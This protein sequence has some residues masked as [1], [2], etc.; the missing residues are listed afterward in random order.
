MAYFNEPGRRLLTL[1]KLFIRQICSVAR[2]TSYSR[3]HI[4][5]L[6][7]RTKAIIRHIFQLFS[8]HY[9][10]TTPISVSVVHMYART[11]APVYN[12]NN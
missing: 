4:Y 6:V 11:Y 3:K 12:T 9:D 7:E 2:R 8:C 5:V 10:T 1:I